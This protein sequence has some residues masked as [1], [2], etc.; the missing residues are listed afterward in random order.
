VAD[1]MQLVRV[2]ETGGMDVDGDGFA[3]LDGSRIY[4]FGQSLGGIYGTLLLAI[5]PAVRA[6]VPN[7]A[8]GSLPE[9]G[10][11]SPAFRPLVGLTLATRVPSLIN[12]G[13]LTFDENLPLR[14]QAPVV[15]TVAGAA[16]IQEFLDRAEW[17]SQ[18]G[19]AVAYAPHVRKAPLLGVSPKS[20]IYQLAKGDQTVPN[21]TTSAILRAGELADRAT[22]FRNDLAY[23]AFPGSLKNPHLFLV[24]ID[25]PAVAPF[26]I[27]AQQQIAMFFASD[28]NVVI[29]PDGTGPFFEVPIDGPLPEE[30]S[31][32]P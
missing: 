28:G 30:L 22:Y 13:G 3:D 1:L 25:L 7:V 2:I 9:I 11:L 31:F 6:G 21:P 29:D 18:A 19:N 14:D 4:Y 17:V 24:R 10:R 16:E 32:I 20:V 27:A 23:A 26:A 8:G 5:D 12:V 15:D